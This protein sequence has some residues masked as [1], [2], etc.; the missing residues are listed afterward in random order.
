MQTYLHPGYVRICHWINAFS[1]LLMVASGWKIYN[2]SPIY[3]FV[4]PKSVTIG[5]WLGGALLWH[6]AAMWVL[7]ANGLLY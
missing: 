1:I 2:A 5:G 6:F 3:H 7:V 4:F